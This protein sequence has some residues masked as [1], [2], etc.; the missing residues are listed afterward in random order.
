MA[1][2]K[3]ER[4]TEE[5][6]VRDEFEVEVALKVTEAR[7]KHLPIGVLRRAEEG[8]FSAQ[9]RMIGHF[10]VDERE[11]YLIDVDT[12]VADRDY[13]PAFAILDLFPLGAVESIMNVLYR[14]IEEASDTDP[15]AKKRSTRPR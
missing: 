13:E 2:K 3:E 8:N 14:Q 12:E 15:K 4:T 5:E 6:E 10:M 9:Q 7:M 1:K 11:A